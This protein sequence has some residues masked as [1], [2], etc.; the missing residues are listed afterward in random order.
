MD[1]FW[2]YAAVALAKTLRALPLRTVARLGRA[3]GGIAYWIDARHRGVALLNLRR[4]FPTRTAA[5]LRPI[6][7]EHFRRLGENYAAAVKTSGMPA[8]RL[9][10]HLEVSGAEKL[11]PRGAVVAIGHFG[12]FELH[13][14]AF[15]NRADLQLATTY[16]ALKQPRLEVL[17][18]RMRD[19]SGCLFFD[20]RRDGAALREALGRGG[21]ALGL[22]SDQHAGSRALRIPFFGHDCSVTSAPAVLAQRY[23][24]PLHTAICFRVALARWR[25]EIGDEI[26]TAHNGLR[27]PPRDVMADVNAVFESAVRRDPANWFWVHDRWRFRKGLDRPRRAEPGVPRHAGATP[28]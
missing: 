17:V 7:R 26:A 28:Q 8:A 13:A 20:R 22:L 4:C 18:R 27:R 5:E 6:L 3:G 25:I 15:L 9:R 10:P 2:Y 11:S 1:L 21:I 12:N 24:L 16:R 14:R 23:R 19:Q